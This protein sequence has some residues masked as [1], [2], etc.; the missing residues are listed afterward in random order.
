MSTEPNGNSLEA[1]VTQV[2]EEMKQE[3]GPDF[4]LSR[5]NL[6][7]FARRAGI[8]R[9]RARHLQQNGF[10]VKPNA[11]KGRKL[12]TTIISGYSGV[13][14][15]LLRQ[16]V[17]NSVVIKEKIT[18]LGYTGGLSTV[19][20][21][22]SDHKDLVPAKRAL[23]A[24]QGSRG[25]R[26]YTEP[27]E[28]FEMD[29][30]FV[31]VNDT[32]E[33][34]YKVACFAMICHHCGKKYIEFFPNARQENLFIGMIHA[35]VFLG[36]PEY[37]LTDNI[38]SV[39]LCRDEQKHP[40]WQHDYEAFMKAI[41]F[42]TKLC[43]PRH[44]FTKGK[45]ERL[46]KYVKENFIVGRMVNNITE[47]NFQALRWCQEQDSRYHQAVDCVPNTEH[48]KY[49]RT[50]ARPLMVNAGEKEI[51]YY[52]YPLRRISFD[53]FV[54]FEGR[55]FGVPHWYHEKTCR[56]RRDKFYIYIYSTDLETKLAQHPVTWSRRD[57]LCPD[58]YVTEQPEELPTA[59]VTASL[60]HIERPVIS[61][62]FDRFNF[63]K[64][65][66]RRHE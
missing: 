50:K 10:E 64:E 11:H 22:I 6:A 5:I 36:I 55:R 32:A 9:S 15:G 59:P 28:C 21:Y 49:C 26:F 35:F 62:G 63:V 1:I 65:V 58:Q 52:L 48:T 12:P 14:D 57:S 56:I 7:E 41:G 43:K 44:P 40:I 23:V 27:G 17:T 25:Q 42:K 13:V 34:P 29:W 38:K 60:T 31:N 39:V 30:G 8:S 4:D 51:F 61:S 47:L 20:T 46:I 53:G 18:A 45:V 2:L 16:G 24:P 3:T 54:N 19:K 37:V 66:E 33:K